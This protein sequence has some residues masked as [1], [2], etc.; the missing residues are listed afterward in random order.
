MV[1][2]LGSGCV[3]GDEKLVLWV[4]ACLPRQLARLYSF[5]KLPSQPL[6]T[7]SDYCFL[8]SVWLLCSVTIVAEHSWFFSV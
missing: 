6:L 2:M 5:Y 7:D 3:S 1:R 8:C 4:H